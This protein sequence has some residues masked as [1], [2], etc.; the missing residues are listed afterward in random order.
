M[1]NKEFDR[2]VCFQFYESYLEQAELV[3]EQL[4]PEMCVEYFQERHRED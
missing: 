1:N 4:G 2:S 3:N